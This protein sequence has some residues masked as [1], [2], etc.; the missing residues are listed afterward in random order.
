[1]NFQPSEYQKT[2]LGSNT[3]KNN[4][5]RDLIIKIKDYEYTSTSS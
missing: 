4:R 3:Q 1:M 2:Q 5:K